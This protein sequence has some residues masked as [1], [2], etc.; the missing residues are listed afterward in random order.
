MPRKRSQR[1]SSQQ[2]KWYVLFG[3][4]KHDIED[5]GYWKAPGEIVFDQEEATVFPSHNVN[6]SEGF[7]TPE[8]WRDF[9]NDDK[10]MSH[11][12]KFHLVAVLP[13]DFAK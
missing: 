7:G 2:V 3:F 5:V 1:K 4:A 8:K 12:Y 10:V 13:R 6:N 11:G 9:I